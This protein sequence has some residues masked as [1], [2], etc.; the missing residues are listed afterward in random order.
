MLDDD[1]DDDARHSLCTGLRKLYTDKTS[2]KESVLAV[3]KNSKG[4]FHD[5]TMRQCAKRCCPIFTLAEHN[6]TSKRRCGLHAMVGQGSGLEGRRKT[7]KEDAKKHE[8]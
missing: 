7:I 4:R 1:G 5:D 8:L 2:I 6:E 3:N